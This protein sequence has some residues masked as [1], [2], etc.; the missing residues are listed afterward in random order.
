MKSAVLR[1]Q[2]AS[3]L[4]FILILLLAQVGSASA[5]TR[6]APFRLQSVNAA[7]VAREYEAFPLSFEPNEGQANATVKYVAH[8]SGYTVFLTDR[9]AVLSL[10]RC[11]QSPAL[12]KLNAMTRG[13]LLAR[14]IGR[15]RMLR[16]Q[17][18]K[19]RTVR[20]S[21][22][23]GSG[24]THLEPLRELPGK[25]SYYIGTDPSKWL[26]NI[27]NYSRVR[28]ENVRPGVDLV[29]YGNGGRLEFD[30]IV[31]PGTNPKTIALK[32]P[33]EEQVRISQ[34]GA[35]RV[36]IDADAIE[37]LPPTAYQVEA[38]EKHFVS[39]E[40]VM[41]SG[42]RVGIQVGPYN[43]RE[44]LII[45]PTLAYST[46]IGGTNGDTAVEGVAVDSTGDVY[47]AGWT[48]STTF[49]IVGGYQT[50]G[51][52]NY[53][54]FVA[55]LDPSA[56]SV[57]WSTYLG[58]SGSDVGYGIALGGNS[59]VYVTGYSL[60]ND[61]PIV[62]GFQTTNQ[63]AAEGNAFVARFDTTQTGGPS[64]VYS[65]YLGGGGNALNTSG[66]WSNDGDFGLGIAADSVGHAYVTGVTTSDSSVAPF[67][68]TANAYQSS[69]GS[70]N[71]NAFLTVIDTTKSGIAS[72][73]YSTY[74]GGNSPGWSGDY[75]NSV[76]IDA[77]GNAYIGGETT[78]NS[79]APFPTTPSAYQSVLNGPG[80]NAF[81]AEIAPAQSGAASLRYSTYFGGSTVD[82]L[83]DEATGVALDSLGNIYIAGG[84]T[85]SDFPVTN[86][87]FQT[88]NSA[89]GKGFVAKF[90]LT[91]TGTQ[92]LVY[93]T[94]LG[95]TDSTYLDTANCIQVDSNGDSFVAGYASS[96]DFPTTPDAFQTSLNSSGGWD[97]FLTE[98]SPDG[99]GLL[100]STYFGGS[101]HF[102]GFASSIALDTLDN[103]YIGGYTQSSDFPTTAGV[104]QT[105]P[106]LNPDA[107]FVA[108][109]AMNPSPGITATASPAPSSDGWN[110]TPVATNFS[111]IPGLAAIESCPAQVV[112]STEGRNQLVSGMVVDTSGLTNVTSLTVNLDMTPP[113]V[114]ITSPPDSTTV[115]T[116]QVTLAGPASD[117]LSGVAGVTCNGV[118]ATL[119]GFNFSCTIP[120]VPGVNSATVTATDLAGNT[121]ASSINVVFSPP[122]RIPTAPHRIVQFR[123]QIV[124]RQE[125]NRR[126]DPTIRRCPLQ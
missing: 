33:G 37:L 97:A 51:N 13:R 55:K 4:S 122:H 30:M 115:A 107:G 48:S 14:K 36:G 44:P 80:G 78:S 15:A 43:R 89:N 118:Q 58:G 56:S 67:P 98:L 18:C 105:T 19:S 109:F 73:I 9:E 45:D 17:I 40:F 65:T 68:T 94:M 111:C 121:T 24:R 79:S 31:A 25:S 74:L 1:A 86:G 81:L 61:F 88:A 75:G 23:R 16:D 20:M 42:A 12:Q 71:G 76:A 104:Y 69:L 47:V 106:S 117:A 66:S 84:A 120:L 112:V 83:G 77:S 103:P 95:G 101:A 39:A 10:H 116:P 22:D 5:R 41:L 63:N 110:N 6:V 92:S 3:T 53:A 49:P 46:F 21:V 114:A 72:L 60:S 57:L 7:Q 54:V 119:N 102:G 93:S 70:S 125:A 113:T 32:F 52:A 11:Q 85:S 62:N 82:A 108:K 124:S 96:T 126:C 64:L 50:T 34:D 38:G 28:Y 27:P 59:N 29:Y 99:S 8:G 91:K 100:Y 90:D 123:P 26:I 2:A 35:A 87:A